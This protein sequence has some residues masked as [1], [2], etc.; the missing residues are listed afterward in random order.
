MPHDFVSRRSLFGATLAGAINLAYATEA[1]AKPPVVLTMQEIGAIEN[2][3]GK[4]GR[5]VDDEAIYTVSLPRNDL[6]VTLKGEPIPVPFGF[7]GWASFKRTRDGKQLMVMSDTVLLQH[8]VTPVMDAALSNGLEI[9]AIHNH[10]FYEEPRIVY[11]H[12]HA[13][14]TDADDLARRYMAS[15][16]PS[17]LHPANQPKPGVITPFSA[18]NITDLDSLIGHKATVNGPTIKYTVG[19]ADLKVW[20]MNVEMTAAIGLNSWAAFAGNMDRARIAG[21]I[22]MLEG[23]VNL[24][25]PV[26]RRFGI[27]V[28]ALHNHML[29]ENPRVV[30]LHY[31][32]AGTAIDMATGFKAAIDILGKKQV[33][34]KM[35]GMRM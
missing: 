10:F 27:E 35:H 29:F 13:M 6:K 32:G 4:K 17:P 25:I 5:S 23:E 21:D 20:D 8:E 3:F 16:L 31:M 24:V 9:A 26:L 14:G 34:S 7:G 28:V 30:F 15:I 1:L 12:L 33:K 22:A 11:M 19:R 2:A 18:F